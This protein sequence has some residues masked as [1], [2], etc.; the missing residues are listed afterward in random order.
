MEALNRF[1]CKDLAHLII[2]FAYDEID[3][4]AVGDLYSFKL[5][6]KP[7][8]R[9]GIRFWCYKSINNA[10]ECNH[11]DILEWLLQNGTEH[12]HD[13]IEHILFCIKKNRLNMIELVHKYVQFEKFKFTTCIVNC[14]LRCVDPD[15]FM[16][17]A[18]MHGNLPI[19]KWFHA[20][21]FKSCYEVTFSAI[22]NGNLDIL[23]WLHENNL[24]AD[25]DHR[26]SM[27][28]VAFCNGQQAALDWIYKI[29]Q[30]QVQETKLMKVPSTYY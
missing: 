4:A 19:L 13:W 27:I 3:A 15:I 11:V 21:G 25:C 12:Y 14:K 10:I 16:T 26:R 23:E 2:R 22:R 28:E 17:Q 9:G 6:Y 29:Y 8:V 20:N 18:A 30:C 1:F 24:L 5:L 7:P